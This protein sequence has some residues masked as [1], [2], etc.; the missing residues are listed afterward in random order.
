MK[1]TQCAV[2]G[3]IRDARKR[4]MCHTCYVRLLN[5]GEI[6]PLNRSLADRLAAGLERKP[7][8][9]L[10][11]TKGKTKYGYGSIGVATKKTDK[12][13]RV[14][15]TLANGPIPDGL[16]VLHHCDN[17]PCCETAPSEA[18]PD[19]H[20]FLGTN[21]D[22]V[23]DKMAK[24]RGKAPKTHCP[25]R[26]EYTEANTYVKPNG[27]RCCRECRRIQAL[28]SYHRKKNPTQG[29]LL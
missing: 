28:A 17:P 11:W 27:D 20:L 22:N 16:H 23:A 2:D 29:E 19:G 9:C 10:E 21:A 4:G 5:R 7:N 1:T 13:H 6:E 12:T 26:H 3:C 15:W 24:G 25:D 14:A 18:Y 8:G